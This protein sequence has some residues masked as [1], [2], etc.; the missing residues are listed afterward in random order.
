MYWVNTMDNKI[1][2]AYKNSLLNAGIPH[3]LVLRNLRELQDHY[4]DLQQLALAK[5]L[6]DVEAEAAASQQLGDYEQLAA[7]VIERAELRSKLHRFP[8][9]T[10]VV[11]PLL[12]HF[13]I[14]V[15]LLIGILFPVVFLPV[16][17]NESLS[18]IELMNSYPQWIAGCIDLIKV[19][20]MYII[21][22]L[23]GCTLAF[24]AIRSHVPGRFW[25][26]GLVLLCLF[27]S[28]IHVQLVWPDPIAG[29]KGMI[30]VYYGFT[31]GQAPAQQ[32]MTY[33]FRFAINLLLG[34]CFAWHYRRKEQTAGIFGNTL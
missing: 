15:L 16:M 12:A 14:C 33:T 5:G 10:T 25:L 17:N 32:V 31:H 11:L 28:S 26:T 23:L 34:G 21:T 1:V 9:G 4:H 13:S 2:T 20:L 19:L 30:G 18:F 27:G 6:I 24:V 7:A 3:A 29:Y 8:I 22:P